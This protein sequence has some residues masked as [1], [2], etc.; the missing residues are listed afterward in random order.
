MG[1]QHC[2]EVSL[3]IFKISTPESSR[4]GG[5]GGGGVEKITPGRTR[6]RGRNQV[7]GELFPEFKKRLR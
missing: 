4:L 2:T 1:V 3:S 6:I 5:G 7:Y